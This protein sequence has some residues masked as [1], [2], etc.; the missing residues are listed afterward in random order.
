[1]LK[2][3]LEQKW[4]KFESRIIQ[5]SQQQTI[6][7][8]MYTS[9]IDY[10][11][12]VEWLCLGIGIKINSHSSKHVFHTKIKSIHV[13]QT[14]AC[15]VGVFSQDINNF[16]AIFLLSYNS[17]FAYTHLSLDS[18]WANNVCCP[19]FC[20][21]PSYTGLQ[22]TVAL[23]AINSLLKSSFTVSTFYKLLP[24]LQIYSIQNLNLE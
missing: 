23:L 2:V 24:F 21:D 9:N 8:Q 3:Q 22:Y 15:G 1:M 20:I 19:I 13:W 10:F 6:N 11:V 17:C 12:W 14:F 16:S 18:F 5:F 4:I 7:F